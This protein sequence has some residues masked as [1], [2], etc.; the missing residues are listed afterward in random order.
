MGVSACL[1]VLQL[2]YINKK[3]LFID[4]YILGSKIKQYII[5]TTH[6][7]KIIANTIYICRPRLRIS[8]RLGG[9]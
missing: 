5:V 3:I 6:L 7:K 9:T 2:S 4:K 8:F 1:C